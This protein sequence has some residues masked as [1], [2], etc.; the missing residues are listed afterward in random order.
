[1]VDYSTN[2][3]EFLD[4]M[5]DCSTAEM[6][7]NSVLYF[8]HLVDPG[9]HSAIHVCYRKKYHSIVRPIWK[10]IIYWKVCCLHDMIK[11]NMHY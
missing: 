5:V 11:T 8:P 7:E 6:H 3:L 10:N 2:K 9:S 4:H 1:M